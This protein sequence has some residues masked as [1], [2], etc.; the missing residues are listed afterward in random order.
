MKFSLVPI[1]FFACSGCIK[2][3]DIV[4]VDRATALEQQAA[5]SFQSL[6][7]DL[8]QVG[9]APKPT[10]YSPEQL[11]AAG[12]A[13]P[14]LTEEA[15]PSD[16]ERVD[17]LL[18]GRCIGESLDGTLV[19]THA[20]CANAEDR[21]AVIALV[22]RTN[23]DRAQIWRWL[24]GQRP[25]AKPEEVRRAWRE[26]HLKQVICGGQVQTSDGKWGEKRC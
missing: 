9:I 14:P 26:V 22:D 11:A 16:A 18:K 10:P 13:K 24:A 5:G 20:T 8:V 17:A 4:L 23:R 21:G 3:P 12:I 15:E 7:D 19:D 6:E 1:F 25:K 2:A